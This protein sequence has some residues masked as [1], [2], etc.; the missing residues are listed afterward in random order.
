MAR[1]LLA[2]ALAAATVTSVAAWGELPPALE[3]GFYQGELG[4]GWEFGVADGDGRRAKNG[5]R[6]LA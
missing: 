1:L 4:D 3:D 2:S 5:D 6:L